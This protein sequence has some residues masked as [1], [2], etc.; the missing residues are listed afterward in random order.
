MHAQVITVSVRPDQVDNALNMLKAGMATR[1]RP[2]GQQ[3]TVV[4]GDRA[5]GQAITINFW[6]SAA[7]IQADAAAL[8]QR[9]APL[10]QFFTGAPSVAVYEVMLDQ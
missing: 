9:L 3:R 7:S 8:Q 6:D 2:Q 10:A 4:L 5:T 1:T